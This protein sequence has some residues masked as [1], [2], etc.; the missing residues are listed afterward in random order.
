MICCLSFLLQVHPISI[1][2]MSQSLLYHCFNLVIAV[3]LS[4]HRTVLNIF[5]GQISL[6][7]TLRHCRSRRGYEA[8]KTM[9][10]PVG[11]NQ[12]NQVIRHSRT[13]LGAVTVNVNKHS[14][15]ADARSFIPNYLLGVNL[16][17]IIDG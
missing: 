5:F 7:P 16:F 13:T 6:L 17:I 11:T 9:A 2:V 12:V 10:A 15:S 1:F 14:V 4:A 8:P 3:M